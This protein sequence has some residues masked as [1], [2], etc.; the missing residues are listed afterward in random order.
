MTN[1][2]NL[3][4]IIYFI[5]DFKR[6][7]QPLIGVLLCLS[8]VHISGFAGE[9]AEDGGG[10]IEEGDKVPELTLKNLEGEKI[11]LQSA[12][13]KLVLVYFWASW[14]E[15]SCQKKILEF[16]KLYKKYKNAP[17]KSADEG[18]TVYLISLDKQKSR[19]KKASE[20]FEIPWKT[21]MSD[22]KG[23]DSE[24]VNKFGIG[25]IPRSFLV[26][27]D[28]IVEAINVGDKLSSILEKQ[29]K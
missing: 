27:G 3:N 12:E 13:G 20:E 18:F 7:H 8:I 10:D 9:P 15:T 28:G 4:R 26:N 23:W 21:N 6:K 5:K 19:W 24:A 1:N 25:A 2:H 22:L 14:C 17:F 29:K 11:S 16:E